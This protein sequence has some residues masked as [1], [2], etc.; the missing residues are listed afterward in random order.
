MCTIND[1]KQ[2]HIL[3]IHLKLALLRNNLKKKNRLHTGNKLKT[4]NT[5]KTLKI[6]KKKN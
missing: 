1:A 3:K 4:E 6:L 5:Q 2:L